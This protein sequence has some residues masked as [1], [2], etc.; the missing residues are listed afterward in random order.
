VDARLAEAPLSVDF[1][2]PRDDTYVA[3][4]RIQSNDEQRGNVNVSL[5]G[6]RIMGGAYIPWE[7]VTKGHGGPIAGTPFWVPLQMRGEAPRPMRE[8]AA[9]EH[10]LGVESAADIDALIDRVVVTNDLGW[11]PEGISSFLPTE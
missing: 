1:T 8:I 10:T 5:D 11:R 6:E 4:V 7:F 9:G 3:W 2:L